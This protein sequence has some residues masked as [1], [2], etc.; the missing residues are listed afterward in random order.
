MPQKLQLK[1]IQIF[2]PGDTGNSMV[3]P[4]SRVLYNPKASYPDANHGAGIFTYKFGSFLGQ[5]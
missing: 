5:M 1:N 3:P 4:K 2:H